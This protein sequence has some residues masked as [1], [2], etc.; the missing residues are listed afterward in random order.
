MP[1]TLRHRAA[2]TRLRRHDAPLTRR[3]FAEAAARR[4]S[5]PVCQLAAAARVPMMRLAESLQANYPRATI[6]WL[7]PTLMVLLGVAPS[8]A[9]GSRMMSMGRN[10]D[11]TRA[12]RFNRRL[13]H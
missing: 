3:A 13:L 4:A 11:G 7:S 2:D 1:P 5:R 6:T 10:R 8:G 12:T 9:L